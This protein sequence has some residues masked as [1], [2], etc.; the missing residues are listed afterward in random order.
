MTLIVNDPNN[1]NTL[2]HNI[3]TSLVEDDNGNLW[4][5]TLGGGLNKLNIESN[6]F[7]RYTPLENS[8][9]SISSPYVMALYCDKK[10]NL[11]IGTY[12]GGLVKL[13]IGTEK[14]TV[15]KFSEN[16]NSISDDRVFSIREDNDGNLWLAAF[17]GGISKFNLGKKVFTNYSNNVRDDKSIRNN[18][19][20]CL[21]IDRSNNLWAGTNESL[22]KVNLN[23]Q[24]FIIIKMIL[25]IQIRFRTTM[26]F[27]S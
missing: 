24:N 5:G 17:G 15:Y 2:S 7:T 26:S 14:F 22:E 3:I 6:K 27:Q 16:K 25:G 19:V 4:I 10:N 9:N 18:F 20:R 8:I 21:L 23:P 1:K 13:E 11:W 12:N